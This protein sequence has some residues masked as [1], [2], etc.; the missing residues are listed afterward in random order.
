MPGLRIDFYHIPT[1]FATF[2]CVRI[3]NETHAVSWLNI[4]STAAM[5]YEMKI[6]GGSF[7]KFAADLKPF[8]SDILIISFD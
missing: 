3:T 5:G 1:E 8:T 6:K 7:Q 2:T 4:R